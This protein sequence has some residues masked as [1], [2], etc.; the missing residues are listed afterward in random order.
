[1]GCPEQ[2]LVGKSVGQVADERGIH[3]CDVF[4]DL[5]VAYGKNFRWKTTIANHRPE[6]LNHML[7]LPHVHVGFADAGAHLRNMAFYN[8]PLHMLKRVKDAE[9]AGRPFM[10]M[11]RAVHKLTGELAQWFD[12]D[13]GVLEIGVRADIA[14]INPKG[15]ND[16]IDAYHEAPIDGMGGISRMVRRNDDAVTATIVGGR[17]AFQSGRF[18]TDFERQRYGRFLKAGVADRDPVAQQQYQ[19]SLAAT[20]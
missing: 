7:S 17:V 14:I 10:S 18:A 20:A 4:L 5:V 13:A 6:V 8:F 3:P 16:D 2:D 12:L 19:P 15:L 9:E 1:V 11:E